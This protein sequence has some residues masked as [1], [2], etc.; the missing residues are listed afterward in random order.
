MPRNIKLQFTDAALDHVVKESYDVRFGARPLRRWLEQ[1]VVTRLS[2]M[3]IG[4]EL[5]DDS[6][7]VVDLGQQ[8]ELTYVV[9]KLAAEPVP[10]DTATMQESDEFFMPTI[11]PT[12]VQEPDD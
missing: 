6:Q 9:T 11:K 4:G 8:G 1:H 2:E 5:G 12:R 7:V 10:M 3:L